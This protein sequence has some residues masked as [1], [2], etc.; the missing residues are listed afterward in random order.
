M[1][2]RMQAERNGITIQ[3]ELTGRKDAPV[4]VLSHCLAGSMDIWDSQVKELEENYRVLRYDTRGHGGSSAP[5]E[6]YT[7]EMLASDVAALIDAASIE[8]VHFVGI[9]MGGMI[10]QTLA[11]MH[12]EKLSSLVLCDTTCMVPEAM[13][14]TWEERIRIAREKGMSPMVEE[15]LARWF[16]P[17]FR[18]SNPGIMDK[19]K[20]IIRATPVSGFAG[21]ARAISRFN[22][23]GKLPSLHIPALIMV[24]ENDPGTPVDAAR[25]IHEGIP[26][27]EMAVL[28][29][30]Y[31]LSNIEAAAAFNKT[32]LQFLAK[33]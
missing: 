6:D 4:V 21:C 1:E 32:M 27:S 16:S 28:P 23:H 11:V 31:H 22:V 30:A 8:K 10:G 3:Y 14:P 33:H 2:V 7:M 12:P 19:I 29:G 20:N 9:S 26:G 5:D 24:G 17:P 18:E 15:T 25:Q 13:Q